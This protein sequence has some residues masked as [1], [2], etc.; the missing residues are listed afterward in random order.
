[1]AHRASAVGIVFGGTHDVRITY[2]AATNGWKVYYDD[3]V[4]EKIS[5]FTISNP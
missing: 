3:M 1:M 5:S 4:N 2:T